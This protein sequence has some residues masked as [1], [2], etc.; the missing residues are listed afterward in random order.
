MVKGSRK[1]VKNRWPERKVKEFEFFGREFR[2]GDLVER[3][4]KSKF[5]AGFHVYWLCDLRQVL[6]P[7]LSLSF[8]LCKWRCSAW[9]LTSFTIVTFG[10]STLMTTT[11][12]GRWGNYTLWRNHWVSLSTWTPPIL[13]ATPLSLLCSK[14]GYVTKFQPLECK[15]KRCVLTFRNCP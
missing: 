13:K 5:C 3:A 12:E 8:F 7:S 6:A 14:C 15:Q 11:R 9:F 1:N 10:E 4:K 2:A